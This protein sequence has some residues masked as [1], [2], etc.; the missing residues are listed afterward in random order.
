MENHLQIEKNNMEH[1]LFL[2]IETVSIT[3]SYFQLDA[4]MQRLWDKKCERIKKTEEQ[5]PEQL[6]QRAG[7]YAEFG[8]VICISAACFRGDKLR[9]KSYINEEEKILLQKFSDL[10]NKSFSENHHKLCAHNGKEFDFPYL[11]RR[12]LVNGISIPKILDV[13][14][15]K[16]WETSFF[17]TMEM[18]KFGDYKSYTSLDL[19]AAVFGIPSPKDDI[20]GSMVYETYW[21]FKNLEQIKTYCEKDVLTVV[22]LFL[23]YHGKEM[24]T[25]HQIV[26]TTSEGIKE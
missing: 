3:E 17:D 23:R 4:R 22:Q 16:P 19:L 11:C 7:I 26:I 24:L 6:Y 25:N 21:K 13:S 2:D 8:K 1:I 14:G 12:M 10:L 20:D 15:K 18:W 5:T 9:V